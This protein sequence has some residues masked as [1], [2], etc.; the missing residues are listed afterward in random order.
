MFVC[1]QILS[2]VKK[3]LS[4]ILKKLTSRLLAI[5]LL[6]FVQCLLLHEIIHSDFRKTTFDGNC[7]AHCYKCLLNGILFLVFLYLMKK[8]E[9]VVL[10]P[11]MMMMGVAADLVTHLK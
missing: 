1:V 9:I 6:S 11:M 7:K 10:V 8:N 5:E 2:M 3:S 4:E